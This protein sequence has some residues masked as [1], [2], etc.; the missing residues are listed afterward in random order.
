M[1]K[2]Y[3]VLLLII[4]IVIFFVSYDEK[5][6]KISTKIIKKE[7]SI[8]F[9]LLTTDAKAI[10]VVL[11]DDKIKFYGYED[12][13]ILLTF[14]ST[15]CLPCKAQ[16]PHLI[17]LQ[18]KYKNKF[19]IIAVSTEQN[20]SNKKLKEFIKEYQLN[21]IV[22]NSNENLTLSKA[23]GDIKTIPTM[24][25]IGKNGKIIEKYVGLIPQEMINIDIQKGLGKK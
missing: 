3:L 9:T 20:I 2:K 15:W 11:E 22:A 1:N 25:M 4:P 24:I 12:K 16:I 13:I 19:K 21:Y 10:R 5:N 14:F 23:L 8:N 18:N 7:N 6:K 17:N